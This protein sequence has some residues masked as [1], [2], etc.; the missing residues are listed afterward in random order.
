MNRKTRKKIASVCSGF[1]TFFLLLLMIFLG[2]VSAAQLSLS[3]DSNIVVEG[4][5]LTISLDAALS[6]SDLANYD[7][8]TVLVFRGNSSTPAGHC[9]FTNAGVEV[10]CTGDFESIE[11]KDSSSS[12]FKA[13]ASYQGSSDYDYCS[14]KD[15]DYS[16]GCS[17]SYDRLLSYKISWKAPQ[18][19]S[20]ENF[21]FVFLPSSEANSISEEEF[22]KA[23]EIKVTP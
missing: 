23:L 21:Y 19:Q 16:Y 9:K 22:N 3:V 10:E 13:S 18:V 7:E 6:S 2:P 12:L 8:F 11:K 14:N 20:E 17:V 15:Y 4:Q 5:P 1:F